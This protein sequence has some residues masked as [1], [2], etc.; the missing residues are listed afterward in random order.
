MPTDDRCIFLELD[1][2]GRSCV[3]VSKYWPDGSRFRRRFPNRT[4]ARKM[5]ARIEEAIAMGTWRELKKELY[6]DPKEDLTIERFS[7]IYLAEYCRIHNT[8]PDFKEET[9]R[10]IVSI[11]GDVRIKEFTRAHA[12]TFEAKRSKTVKGATVNRGLAVL[13]NMLTFALEKGLIEIHPMA[14]YRRI[15]EEE[16]ALRVMTIEEERKLVE[17]TLAKDLAVGVYCGLL[18]E[19]AMRPEEGL[20][21]QWAF[22]NLSQGMLTVDRS[23]TK[24]ARHIPLSDY[25]LELLR[26]VPRIIGCPYVIARLETMERLK[27]PRAPFHNARKATGLDWVTF[28]DFRHFRASQWVIDGV[29]L[30]TVQ[31]LMGHSDIHTTMRYA[32]FAPTHATRSI[33]EAQRREAE[34]LAQQVRDR[35]QTG[36]IGTC[37]S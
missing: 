37:G 12:K 22:I 26:M 24:R 23:K 34:R 9:L 20:R 7:Q 35:R 2:A 32:H 15:K 5:R 17:A 21:Q 1:H 33:I 31:G 27:D 11:I 25:A 8:R 36:D 14:R 13:S 19:T 6:E 16:K 29:D 18:G 28:R 3:V 10:T 4:V 30:K